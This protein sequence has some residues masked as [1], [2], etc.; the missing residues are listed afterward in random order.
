MRQLARYHRSYPV[1]EMV[2]DRYP[3]EGVDAAVNQSVHP[4]S[5]KVV[6]EPWAE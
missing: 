6:I 3:L 5:L 1:D 2:S 4:D